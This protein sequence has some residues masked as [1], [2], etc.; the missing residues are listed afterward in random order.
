MTIL[1]IGTWLVRP[2]KQVEYDRLWK[3]F[4]E[5]MKKNPKLFKEVKSL[6][7]Y[8]QTFGGITGSIVELAEYE[9]FAVYEA[10]QAKMKKNKEY[11]KLFQEFMLLIDPT[12][13]TES[14]LTAIK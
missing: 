13:M 1:V 10:F 4:L 12:A 14:V 3:R 6:K 7:F 8:T 9:S 11:M 2:E 5:F